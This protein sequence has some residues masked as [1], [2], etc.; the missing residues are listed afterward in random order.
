[1]INHLRGIIFLFF[2][3]PGII[4]G[5]YPDPGPDYQKTMLSNPGLTGSEG[6]GRI[7]LS[8]LNYYPGYGYNLFSGVLSCDGYIPSLHGGAGFF[9]SN[10]YMGGIVNDLQGGFSYAYYFQAGEKLFISA[11]LSASLYHRGYNFN[12]SVLPDQID[13]AGGVTLPSGETLF[14]EGKSVLDLATGFLLISDR[15]FWGI[16]VS[17]LT[18]PD[19]DDPENS[20][21]KLGRKLL[22]HGAGDI[23]INK[24]KDLKIRPVGNCEIMK[25]YFSA[26]AGAVLEGRFLSVSALIFGDREKNFDLQTGFALGTGNIEIVYKYRFNIASG[27]NL[28]PF[29]LLHQTGISVGLNNV[30][31]RRIIKTINYPDL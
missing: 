7:R 22:L 9:L 10:D 5:Q 13:Q 8:Y 4:S 14:S 29:S 30:E 2:F 12:G 6:D 26:G 31:K 16:S 23:D 25:G 28:L 20:G 11:G 19:L 3:I 15:F 24:E 21:G 27:T 1:M 17:H 18:E